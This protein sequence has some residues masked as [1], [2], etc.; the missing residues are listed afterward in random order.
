MISLLLFPL[1]LPA[2]QVHWQCS[3]PS[4]CFATKTTRNQFSFVFS[5]G[6]LTHLEKNVSFY[7]TQ[8]HVMSCHDQVRPLQQ[9]QPL[10]RRSDTAGLCT[11]P[12]FALPPQNLT[13]VV[14]A[15]YTTPLSPTQPTSF[16]TPSSTHLHIQNNTII[17][18]SVLTD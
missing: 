15:Y 16:P 12:L 11:H 9:P 10:L 13:T 1:S 14:I 6:E 4:R 5:T 7:R 18:L 3:T 17:R 2:V 8:E